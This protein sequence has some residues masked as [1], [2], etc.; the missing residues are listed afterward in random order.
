MQEVI[1]LVRMGHIGHTE[2]M[3]ETELELSV[4]EIM[5]T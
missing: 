1:T 5:I 4:G 3:S 2:Q